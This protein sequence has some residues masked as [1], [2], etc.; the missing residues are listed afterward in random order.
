[1][2]R[3]RVELQQLLEDTLGSR[4]VYFNPPATIKMTYPAIVYERSDIENL[5]A[6]NLPYLRHYRYMLTV[7]DKNP[8]SEHVENVSLL[9][10]CSYDRH[11]VADNLHHDVFT[12]YF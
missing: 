4:H 10:A 12:I 7:I 11:Y 1:M 5:A 3:P 2:P 6:D 8:D 9:P